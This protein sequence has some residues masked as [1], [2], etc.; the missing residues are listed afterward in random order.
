MTTPAEAPQP[1]RIAD[2]QDL[3]N[4]L[5]LAK[6]EIQELHAVMHEEPSED[7]DSFDVRF[8]FALRR[9]VAGLDARCE[10]IV[11]HPR[12]RVTVRAA[13][14]YDADGPIDYTD[15]DMRE[16]GARVATMA[17]YPYL[18]QAVSDLA[19]RLGV[20]ITLPLLRP[21]MLALDSDTAEPAAN[22]LSEG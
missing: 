15:D 10:I 13:S 9:R 20:S 4:V 18:R 12:C 6:V 8:D 14:F 22:D 5:E 17:L 1:V 2:L 3:V 16:F 19:S 21:G 7:D 11:P